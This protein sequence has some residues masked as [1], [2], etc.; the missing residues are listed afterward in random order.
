MDRA[1]EMVR[2]RFVSDGAAQML[3]YTTKAA[4]ARAYIADNSSAVPFLSAEASARDMTVAA[5]AHEV[6]AMVEQ[7]TMIGSRIEGR[8]MGA[9]AAL[10]TASNLAE[11]AV[12]IGIDWSDVTAA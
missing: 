8:R 10:G 9:K 2:L 11:I 1:A 3:T 6:M 4:E 12:A 5:L 7:W